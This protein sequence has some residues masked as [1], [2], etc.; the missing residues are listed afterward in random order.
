MSQNGPYPGQPWLGGSPEE[1][2]SE[3]ADPWSANEQPWSQPQIPQQQPPQPGWKPPAEWK[4]PPARRGFAMGA[5]VAV[6]SVL[7]G[8]GVATGAWFLLGRDEKDKTP[9]AATTTAPAGPGARPQTSED[10]RFAAKGQCVRN[11]GTDDE[12]K[13]RVVVCTANTYQ[14]LRRID[15]KT[16]GEK[17]AVGKCSKVTGYTKWYYYD[18][19]YDDVDFVLCLKEYSTV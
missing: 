4:P 10:A 2:Y 11:E 19:E 18:T 8:G 1:P 17:D 6:L 3:P 15:G 5:L 9:V 7:I 16:T 12:P 14:V 13:L